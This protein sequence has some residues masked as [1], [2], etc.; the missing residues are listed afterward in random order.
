MS[1]LYLT[2]NPLLLETTSGR[3]GKYLVLSPCDLPWYSHQP[4]I[5]QCDCILWAF[6]I[7]GKNLVFP[8]P[9][10]NRNNC[11]L[12]LQVSPYLA[13][14]FNSIGKHALS[15]HSSFRN[16]TSSLSRSKCAIFANSSFFLLS[17]SVF[18]SFPLNN[19]NY[20]DKM[21]SGLPITWSFDH[22]FFTLS[23][24]HSTTIHQFSNLK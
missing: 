22:Q 11:D 2:P 21:K 10:F 14:S 3:N 18:S 17:K 24:N 1:I 7:V 15:I 13:I 19:C 16:V 23:K 4:V 6:P 5:S 12:C 8:P 9:C 20:F